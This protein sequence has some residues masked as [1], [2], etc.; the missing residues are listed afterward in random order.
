MPFGLSNAPA[1]F[2]RAINYITQGLEGTSAYLDDLVVTSDDWVEHVI[3]LRRLMGRLQEAGL[4]INLAKSTFG[5][6]TVVYLGHVVGNG[7]VRPK[8]ANVE[9]ILDFPVPTTR[10]ALM[11]FLGMAGFY[12][13]FCM[14]F[15]TLAAPL[16]DL[17]SSSVPFHWTPICDQAFHHLKTFLSSEP[18]VWTPDHSRPFHLQV[19]ASGVGV[20]AVLLQAD[21]TSN[22]FHPIA[23]H[24]AKLKKHQL[25]Y[26]TIDKEA[27][28]LVLALQRFECYLH[29]GTQITKIF[30]DHNPLAFLH[31][32]KNKNQRIL[33]WALLTQPFNLEV[34]HIKGMDNIIANTL[35]RSP[36]SPP[37]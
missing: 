32:M 27:L 35:S 4:T 36:I 9:A 19:D 28:A 21:P 37:L 15:S 26:S 29:P 2:Q 3:R 33:R 16:T 22:I 23:Y 18:V 8:R 14:N 34:H 24:S 12:R 17:T 11:R 13:R 6:S 30:T 1:T 7:K 31:A 10:K 25:N 5:K 20:G